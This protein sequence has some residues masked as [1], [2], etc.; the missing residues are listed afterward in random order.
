[1]KINVDIIETG[2]YIMNVDK[3]STERRTYLTNVEVLR[4]KIEA[5]GLKLSYIA[6]EL[7]ISRYG[8]SKKLNCENEFKITEMKQLCNILKLTDKEK[9]SIFFS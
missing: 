9:I 5:S 6:A 8:L 2:A 1:M 7:G 3:T 4:A